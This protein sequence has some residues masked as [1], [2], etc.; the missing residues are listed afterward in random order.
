[1]NAVPARVAGVEAAGEDRATPGRLLQPARSSAAKMV[2]ITRFTGWAARRRLRR[3]PTAP[4]DLPV[5]KIVGPGTPTSRAAKRHVF[6][7][8][9]ID[10]IAGPSEI[11][12]VAD[13]HNDPAVDRRRFCWRKQNTTPQR[14]RCSCR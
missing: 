1:M 6:G 8:V 12:V 5:D 11:L 7:R 3:S 10:M 13:R 2:G 9:G 14:R 4:D